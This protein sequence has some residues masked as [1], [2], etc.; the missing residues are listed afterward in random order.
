MKKYILIAGVNGAGK[1]TLYQ[2]LDSLKSMNRVNSDEIVRTFGDWQN[3][4]D[5][6]KAGKIAVNQI[7]EFIIKGIT[8]NQET[9]LCGNSIIKNIRRAKDFGF[10]IEMHY[11]GLNDVAIAKDRIRYRVEHGGH[12]IPDTDVERRYIESMN[13]LRNVIP[14]A[15]IVILYDNSDT[16]RRFAIYKNGK[17]HVISRNIPDW[18]RYIKNEEI[19]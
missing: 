18:Y 6:I 7:N 16:F 9:T 13:Q 17:L 3:P 14:I 11:V 2:T 5:V 15:N 12:G 1:S 10:I 4:D 8:F 19:K